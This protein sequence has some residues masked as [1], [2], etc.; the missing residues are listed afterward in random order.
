MYEEI[1]YS[2]S[3]LLYNTK[4]WKTARQYILNF[5]EVTQE[6]CF[7]EN[8]QFCEG[9]RKTV[10]MQECRKYFLDILPDHINQRYKHRYPGMQI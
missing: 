4:G 8:C 9:S 6:F 3:R 5:E 7:Q 1:R 10:D 2:W